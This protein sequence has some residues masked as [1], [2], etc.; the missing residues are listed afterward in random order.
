MLSPRI[1]IGTSLSSTIDSSEERGT[2]KNQRF[3]LLPT[4]TNS[5]IFLEWNLLQN[6]SDICSQD[7]TDP[8]A[9]LVYQRSQ[10]GLTGAEH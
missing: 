9:P 8:G 5:Q 7:E 10:K 2:A 3:P 6:R 1:Q 4:S